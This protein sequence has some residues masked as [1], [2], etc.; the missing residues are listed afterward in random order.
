[1]P[2]SPGGS[3]FFVTK[4]S[5]DDPLVTETGAGGAVAFLSTEWSLDDPTVTTNGPERPSIGNLSTFFALRDRAH[6]GVRIAL[7]WSD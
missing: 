3:A 2:F 5:P 1:M 4:R 6:S 7:A